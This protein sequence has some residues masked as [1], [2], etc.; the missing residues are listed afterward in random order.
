MSASELRMNARNSL[1]GNWG[2]AA[3]LFLCYGLTT[4]VITFLLMLI[5]FV[6][7]IAY[8]AISI[9]ISYGFISSF[10][11]LKRGEDVKY[12]GF[13]ND[14]FSNFGRAWAVCGH[15]ILKMIIPIIL[16][17][18]FIILLVL[19]GINI[20]TSVIFTENYNSIASFSV[21]S[22]IALIGYIAS[23]VYAIIKGLLYSITNYILYDNPDMTA[24]EIVEESERLMKGN[25]CQF[26][27]LGFTF[28]GWMILSIFTLYI[29]LLWLIPYI[30]I[31]IVCFYE[32]L[33]GKISKEE[34]IESKTEN[35]DPISE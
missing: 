10:I 17:L 34:V 8:I 27:W 4:Y 20:G 28:I 32:S 30:V 3:L 22:L 26:V 13:L 18:A 1:K 2:K 25:R 21:L 16:A 14:A 11:K 31:S 7:Y 19:S 23:I 29:G 9:P 6:G 5:P 33:S 35:N 15:V 24:K 12:F